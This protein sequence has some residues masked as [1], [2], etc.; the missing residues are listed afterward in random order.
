MAKKEV[1]IPVA[2]KHMWFVTILGFMQFIFGMTTFGDVSPSLSI[3]LLLTGGAMFW[4]GNKYGGFRLR[5]KVPHQLR[6]TIMT[7]IAIFLVLALV[8]FIFSS[9]MI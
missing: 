7:T 5:E 3:F 9:G 4:I 6:N 2:A 8:I 1:T